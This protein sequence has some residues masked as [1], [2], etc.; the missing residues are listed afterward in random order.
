MGKPTCAAVPVSMANEK[1][2]LSLGCIGNRV[3]TEI[4]KDEMVVTIP[5]KELEK[6]L[7]SLKDIARANDILETC[8]GK[9]KKVGGKEES[10]SYLFPDF[11]PPFSPKCLSLC[12]PLAH[13]SA[14]FFTSLCI[15]PDPLGCSFTVLPF[16]SAWA[17]FAAYAV[18]RSMNIIV[19]ASSILV[20]FIDPFTKY[21]PI[22]FSLTFI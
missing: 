15:D 17:G 10:F 1:V 19:P 13:F 12:F 6:F 7:S 18:A 4:G 16:S 21:L 5:G 20:V 14:S 9:K 11:L 8:I 2:T 3:Y 22:V